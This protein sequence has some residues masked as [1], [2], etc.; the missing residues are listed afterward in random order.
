MKATSS[1][2][3]PMPATAGTLRGLFP[4]QPVRVR[5]FPPAPSCPCL[6][7]SLTCTS[8]SRMPCPGM[9]VPWVGTSI[10]SLQ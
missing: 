3:P 4:P 10:L 7:L 8:S 5:S 1:R 2:A 6:P 9:G